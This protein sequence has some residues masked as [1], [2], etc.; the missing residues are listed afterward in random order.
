MQPNN[1]RNNNNAVI[2]NSNY[3]V[4]LYEALL[5]QQLKVLLLGRLLVDLVELDRALG[6]ELGGKVEQA[7]ARIPEHLLFETQT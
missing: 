3:L 1:T 7:V 5:V 6:E 2:L 4:Q